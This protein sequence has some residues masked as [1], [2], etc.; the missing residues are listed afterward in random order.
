VRLVKPIFVDGELVAFVA[1]L[2]HWTDVGGSVPGSI[3]PLARDAYAEGLR[4]TPVKIVDGGTY[5]R[6]VVEMILANVRLPHEATGDVWAQIKAVELGEARL[7]ALV[8]RWGLETIL[9]VFGLMQDH[10]ERLFRARLE[11]IPD[12]AVEFEDFVD[13]DPLDQARRPVRVHLRL[14]KEG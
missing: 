13:V 1:D 10:A 8:E 2:G 9:S 11:S 14:E 4:I 6:D 7:H 5:R 3:N 12:G